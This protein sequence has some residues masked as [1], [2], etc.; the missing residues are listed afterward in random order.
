[1]ADQ[2]IEDFAVVAPS[3]LH[4]VLVTEGFGT[5]I[6]G[7]RPV[8]GLVP[9]WQAATVTLP[10]NRYEHVQTVAAS[11]VTNEDTVALMLAPGTDEAE[12]VPEMLSLTAMS[13]LPG[14]DEITVT[15]EFSEPS[16]GPVNI[17]W[18]I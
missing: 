4:H 6:V 10:G 5:P 3:P 16:S 11:G 14:A 17:L 12:N 2:N 8:S 1:M 18:R 13:A 7:Q 15:L 9:Q